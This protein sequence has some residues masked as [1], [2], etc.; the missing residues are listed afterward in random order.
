MF[1]GTY[2]FLEEHISTLVT[3]K[4]SFGIPFRKRKT[5]KRIS[6]HLLKFYFNFL[7]Y[8]T[9]SNVNEQVFA[10]ELFVC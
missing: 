5:F 10:T 2:S 1:W 6:K 3:R 4:G 8:R 7:F 9:F